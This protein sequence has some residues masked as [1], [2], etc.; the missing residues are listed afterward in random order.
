MLKLIIPAVAALGF[1]AVAAQSYAP[2]AEP[3][4][5]TPVMGWHLSHEDGIAKLAYGVANSDQLALLLMCEPGRST[6]VVY[7]EVQPK[8]AR[9]TQTA[10][11]PAEM[12]PL[13]GGDAVET[14]ISLRDPVMQTLARRGKL[15]VQGEA[16]DFMLEATVDERRLIGEFFASCA[17]AK[18]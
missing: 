5:A 9:L 13:S 15:E 3:I 10:M 11:G 2:E 12:D 17:T 6:A 18:V 1:T 4:V 16:G 14:R 7:G 8:A